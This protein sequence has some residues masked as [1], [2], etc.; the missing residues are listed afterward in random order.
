MLW[1]EQYKPVYFIS[2]LYTLIWSTECWLAKSSRKWPGRKH[3]AWWTSNEHWNPRRTT[4]ANNIL[5]FYVGPNQ[6]PRNHAT[7]TQSNPDIKYLP[8]VLRRIRN[9]EVNMRLSIEYD[10]GGIPCPHCGTK[11]HVETSY[12]DRLAE[13]DDIKTCPSCEH[14]IHGEA[15]IKIKLTKG[16]PKKNENHYYCML[17]QKRPH[18]HRWQNTLALTRGITPIQNPNLRACGHY[19]T[20]N[21]PI[22]E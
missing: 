10:H 14:Y 15:E 17:R 4:G 11:L 19:G 18:R 3:N 2:A 12:E 6:Q 8:S 9:I 13:I 1:T 5:H 16:E 20:W 21:L 7:N 22:N